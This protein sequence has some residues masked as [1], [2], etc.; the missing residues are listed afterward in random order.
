MKRRM[1]VEVEEEQDGMG[2]HAVVWDENGKRFQVPGYT[3][4]RLG[5]WRKGMKYRARIERRT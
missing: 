2:Y 1:R 3:W 5:S 4:G